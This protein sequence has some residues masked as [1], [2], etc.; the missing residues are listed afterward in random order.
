MVLDAVVGTGRSCRRRAGG[1][2][3]SYYADESSMRQRRQWKSQCS[4]SKY[5]TSNYAEDLMDKHSPPVLCYRQE[6]LFDR[7]TEWKRAFSY[8]ERSQKVQWLSSQYHHPPRITRHVFHIPIASISLFPSNA[9][10]FHS[11]SCL[12]PLRRR[13]PRSAQP[14]ARPKSLR[15]EMMVWPSSLRRL[16]G[17]RQ[18]RCTL[19][20]VSRD[21][22]WPYR[23][24]VY[25]LYIES[26]RIDH[27]LIS[28]LLLAG[29][30]RPSSAT[31]SISRTPIPIPTSNSHATSS[32]PRSDSTFP[33]DQQAMSAQLEA[34]MSM[35]SGGD[36]AGTGGMPDMQRLM[37][38]MMGVDPSGSGQNLL[39][40]LDDPA[41]LGSNGNGQ[42]NDPFGFQG[43]ANGGFPSFSGVPT[44]KSKVERYFPS[45]HAVSVI[46]LLVFVV[47]WW[48]PNLGP[49][50][51]TDRAL[52]QS[53]TE[54]WALLAGRRGMWRAMKGEVTAGV[55]V[56]VR[57]LLRAL[58]T[59]SINV[60]VAAGLLGIY[61]SRTHSPDHPFL[62]PQRACTVQKQTART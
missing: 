1:I 45:I 57:H 51:W 21:P 61:H 22:T 15:E 7:A 60:S 49:S 35:F 46:A 23:V 56:L 27:A 40:D 47:A 9:A 12:R 6:A 38:Q 62:H 53:W 25:T 4:A 33:Q 13:T 2:S 26:I 30:S 32:Q 8:C 54:R 3:G 10:P 43:A 48:E 11:S 41:G 50:K 5:R 58:P 20:T 14:H 59:Y 29:S 18:T 52:K 37:A 31:A 36:G 17:M 42:P 28:S 39:G 16:V 24:R 55:E 44:K 19:R 34:M